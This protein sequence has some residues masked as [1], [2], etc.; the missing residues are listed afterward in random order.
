MKHRRNLLKSYMHFIWMTKDRLPLVT[1]EIER[2]VYRYIEKVC[3]EAKCDVLAIGGMPDHVHLLVLFPTTLSFS[4]LMKRVKGGSSR[5]ITEKLRHGEWFEWRENYAVFAVSPT[6][7]DVV[8]EYINNQKT[9]HADKKL[10]DSVEDIDFL[11]ET[12]TQDSS[13]TANNE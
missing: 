4:E 9:R 8:L 3:R 10:W 11:V 2:D 7:K 12:D 13:V 6:H 1:N 5:F